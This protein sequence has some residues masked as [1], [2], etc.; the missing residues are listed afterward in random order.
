MFSG[1][2]DGSFDFKTSILQN[3]LYRPLV[4][5]A[6]FI[7]IALVLGL[8]ILGFAVFSNKIKVVIGLSGA[9]FLSTIAAYIAFGFFANPL[10]A[11]ETTL[12]QI[13]NMDGIIAS[14]IIGFLGE[15]VSF[16]LDGA[17]WGLVFI[18]LGICVWSVSVLLVNKSEEKEKAM[19]EAAR[20]YR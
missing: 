7:M 18:M 19:K 16:T 14:A 11:G 6:I 3:E 4:V 12:S 9:G 20:K 2:S 15:V 13:L 17:F 1:F 5:A 8:V 10:V